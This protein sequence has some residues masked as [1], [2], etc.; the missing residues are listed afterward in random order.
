MLSMC[1]DER[2][3]GFDTRPSNTNS[4][5]ADLTYVSPRAGDVGV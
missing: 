4:R 2:D 1:L 3:T 5:V